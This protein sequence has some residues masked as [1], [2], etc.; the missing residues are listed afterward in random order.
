VTFWGV[1]ACA[2]DELE[3]L[4]IVTKLSGENKNRRYSYQPYFELL[5]W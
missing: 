1:G 2:V 5:S 4:D 3:G